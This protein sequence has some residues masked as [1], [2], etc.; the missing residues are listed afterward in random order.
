V[1]PA[2]RA[3]KARRA[4]RLACGCWVQV[5]ARIIRCPDGKWKC[6]P[7]VLR[8]LMTEPPRPGRGGRDE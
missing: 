5:G 1:K 3:R 8:P 7:C 2:V 4:S 6:V